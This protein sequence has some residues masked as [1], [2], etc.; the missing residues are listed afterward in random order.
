MEE[1]T[2]AGVD[3][4]DELRNASARGRDMAGGFV[5]PQDQQREVDL[6]RSSVLR[7]SSRHHLVGVH[8]VARFV[9]AFVV[10]RLFLA[11]DQGECLPHA[12]VVDELVAAMLFQ[13]LRDL[14]LDLRGV[15]GG[16]SLR[17]QIEDSDAVRG[18]GRSQ[19]QAEEGKRDQS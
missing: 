8:Q 9:G 12:L 6:E 4:S 7:Q 17:R 16:C 10:A 14:T 3:L 19:C 5:A 13:R 1:L 15:R 2:D 18:I 11:T